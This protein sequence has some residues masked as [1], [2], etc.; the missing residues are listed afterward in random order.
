MG[1][2]SWD[3]V[4]RKRKRRRFLLILLIVLLLGATGVFGYWYY[5]EWKA[6]KQQQGCGQSCNFKFRHIIC[7]NLCRFHYYRR[8]CPFVLSSVNFL[9]ALL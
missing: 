1:Y 7:Y 3:V 2:T 9:Q 5:T 8:F 4:E 6:D